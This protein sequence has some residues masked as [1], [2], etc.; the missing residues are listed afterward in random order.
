MTVLPVTIW[1]EPVLHRRA[2]EVEVFDDE[3]R[4]LIADM[5]ETNDAANGVGLAAPQ[6]GVGKRLFVYK[7]ANDDDV[8]EQGV[9]VNPV[10]TLSKVSGALPDPDEHV[11]GC[12][13]FPGEYY[14]LQRAEWTRVQG[15]DGDGNPVDFEAT[16]W[17]ARILQHEYDHLDGKLYVNRLVDRYSKK[18]LKQAKKHGWGVPGLTWMPGV[19]PDPFGH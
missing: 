8:P 2:S 10:L 9:V 14:P 1:G 3:L 18:A 11:E 17:F 13:S 7:Y 15:F 19:D 5:F 6:I 12:L 16:G 4:A